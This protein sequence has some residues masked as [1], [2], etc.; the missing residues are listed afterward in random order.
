MM[1]R[2]VWFVGGVAAGAAGAGYAKRKVTAT[3]KRLAPANVAKGA[4]GTV[5]RSG[6]RVAD[7]VREGRSAAQVRERELRAERDGRL[8]RIEDHLHP[9]DE[10]LVDGEPVESGRVILMRRPDAHRPP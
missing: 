10:L 2:A 9:G 3:A 8:V 7:A 6:Q 5:R 1:R 4:V